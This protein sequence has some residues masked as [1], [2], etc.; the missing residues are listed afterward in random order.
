MGIPMP[1]YGDWPMDLEVLRGDHPGHDLGG[2]HARNR[3]RTCRGGPRLPRCRRNARK[4]RAAAPESLASLQEALQLL[5]PAWYRVAADAS[6]SI[7]E[8]H[9]SREEQVL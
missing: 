9:P 3:H 7:A 8:R 2:V 1:P 5:S 6:A 4:P